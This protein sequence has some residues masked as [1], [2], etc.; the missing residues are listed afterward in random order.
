MRAAL[1]LIV[2]PLALSCRTARLPS[3]SPFAPLSSRTPGEAW[4]ELS[5]RAREFGGARAFA[6]AVTV[7]DQERRSARITLTF[8]PDGSFEVD[9]LSPVGTRVLNVTVRDRQVILHQ[10]GQQRP[11]AELE[12]LTGLPLENLTSREIAMLLLGLPAHEH[13]TAGGLDYEVGDRGLIEVRGGGTVVR[14][15]PPVFPPTRV[16]V[17]SGSGRSFELEYLE[18]LETRN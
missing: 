11:I 3:G 2:V 14:Y 12:K 9:L 13:A 17:V 1:F 4:A 18:L 6:R 5:H 8:Q 10:S 16:R 15:D 7:S